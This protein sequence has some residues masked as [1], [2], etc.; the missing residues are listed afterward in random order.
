MFIEHA[1][2]AKSNGARI[3]G[4]NPVI[5]SAYGSISDSKGYSPINLFI[6][7]HLGQKFSILR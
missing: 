2:L 7:S 6:F 5:S 1:L 3:T 4:K